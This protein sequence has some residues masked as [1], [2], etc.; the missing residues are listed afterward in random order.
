M[1][2]RRASFCPLLCLRIAVT[3]VAVPG[4]R[5]RLHAPESVKTQIRNHAA[6]N[7]ADWMPDG[8]IASLGEG[9]SFFMQASKGA[10]SSIALPTEDRQAIWF[11]ARTQC[12]PP[13]SVQ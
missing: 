13:S 6:R 4:A 3:P 10:W 8:K 9:K 7:F 1:K 11:S 12:A 2:S 5:R